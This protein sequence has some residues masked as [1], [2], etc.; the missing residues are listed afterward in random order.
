MHW[1]IPALFC[2]GLLAFVVA[3]LWL[4]TRNFKNGLKH[5]AGRKLTKLDKMFTKY[6]GDPHDES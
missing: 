1:I 6:D 3:G 2:G 5:K 4:D